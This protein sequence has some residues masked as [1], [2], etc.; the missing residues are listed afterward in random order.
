MQHA[1]Q[2]HL[3]G[4]KLFWAPLDAQCKKVLDIGTGTGIW[5]IDFAD[6]FPAAEVTGTDISSIQPTWVPPNCSFEID[7]AESDWTWKPNTF[8]YIHNRNF[9]CCIRNWPKLI[10]QSFK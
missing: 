7:D 1:M 10:Q 3:L 6:M 9:I 2:G 8:D 4:D 5:A